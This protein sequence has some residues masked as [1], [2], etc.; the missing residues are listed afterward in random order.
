[1]ISKSRNLFRDAFHSDRFY[2]VLC[3]GE[4]WAL[5]MKSFL[6]DAGVRCLDYASVIDARNP[7]FRIPGD[8][9]P[10]PQVYKTLAEKI[11]E[12]VGLKD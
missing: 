2:V 12:D 11:A 1:M 6:E 8:P 3:P 9:H 4:P 7:A 5:R 10:T